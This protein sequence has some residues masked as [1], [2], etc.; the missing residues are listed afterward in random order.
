MANVI[1]F[2]IAIGSFKSLFQE[3]IASQKGYCQKHQYKYVLVDRSP[4]PLR[5]EEASWLKLPFLIAGLRAGHELAVFVDAD[6]EIRSHTPELKDFLSNKPGNIFMAHGHSGR[7]NAGFIITR[8]SEFAERFL[9]TIIGNVDNKVPKEDQAPYENGHVIHY[10][11]HHQDVFILDHLL[12]NNNSKI[13]PSSYIQH[14]SSGPLRDFWLKHHAPFL[15]SLG[16]RVQRYL[17]KRRI[18][19]GRVGKKTTP[20]SKS[21]EELTPFFLDNYAELIRR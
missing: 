18:R 1:V 8:Q 17:K 15:V 19:F 6:I 20:V 4:R 12:W 9:K 16:P 3:C 5:P 2:S 11:K 13:D 7:I 14:Y 10:S 21:L